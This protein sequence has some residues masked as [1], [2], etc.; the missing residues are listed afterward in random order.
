MDDFNV[1]ML[2][3]ETCDFANRLTQN[4]FTPFYFPLITMPARITEHTATLI[5]KIF[6]NDLEKINYSQNGPIFS[7][8]SDHLPIQYFIYV[9]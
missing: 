2:K 4:L 3:N 9:E 6:S 1:D 8:I 7:D 5:D